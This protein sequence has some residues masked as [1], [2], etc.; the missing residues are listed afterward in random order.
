M[1]KVL[2][3]T[4]PINSRIVAG[5]TELIGSGSPTTKDCLK[6]G[7]HS[8]SRECEGLGFGTAGSVLES[9]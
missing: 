6:T 4:E 2:G 5:H 9:E 8:R 7:V 3:L 1:R